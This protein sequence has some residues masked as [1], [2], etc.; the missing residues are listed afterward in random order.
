MQL[1]ANL[2][3]KPDSDSSAE[4]LARFRIA[5]VIPCYKVQREIEGVL[6]SIPTYVSHIVVVNDASPDS[7]RAIVEKVA[8]F[9]QRILLLN[10][11][12][13]QGVGGAMI[14]GFKAAIELGA[15]VVVKMD[16]DGQMKA[17]DLPDLVI[18]LIHG[19]ADYTKG[20]RFRDFQALRQMPWLRRVGNT[21]L[22]FLVKVATG[23]WNCF[24]PCNGFVAIRGDVL[25]QIPLD[26]I[27][28]SYFFETSMLSQ[29]N[30]L[31]ALVR[32]IPLP[33]SY[34]NEVSNLSI[35]KVMI[36]F[37]PRLLAVF[38]RRLVLK[39]FVYD[40][41]LESVHLLAGLPMLLAG[42]GY[43]GYN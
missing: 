34:G 2:S 32:D 41:T 22:S 6:S 21:G 29:L 30:L 37:P 31:H 35:K 19:E 26:K 4:W 24:D 42:L 12:S 25:A 28:R 1:P 14:T 5:V 8:G 27:H 33:A 3:T 39:N 20:N 15:Q 13:N 7:T 43:G 36:E 17:N 18:P 40:F 23:Y 9:D 11:T 38:L 10:H 16:G